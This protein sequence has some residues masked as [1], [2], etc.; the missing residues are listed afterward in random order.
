MTLTFVSG[1]IISLRPYNIR[2]YYDSSSVYGH[3]C[4]R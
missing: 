4:E 3:G 2:R 1:H